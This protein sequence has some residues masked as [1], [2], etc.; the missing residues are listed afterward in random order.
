MEIE[1]G[2]NGGKYIRCLANDAHRHTATHL[3]E[4]K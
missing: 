4:R 2:S 1:M 3:E